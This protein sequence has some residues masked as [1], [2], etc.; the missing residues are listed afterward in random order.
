[1]TRPTGCKTDVSC[2]APPL[3]DLNAVAVVVDGY[4]YSDDF[5]THLYTTDPGI[6]NYEGK[7]RIDFYETGKTTPWAWGE[8]TYQR[9]DDGN[10]SEYQASKPK[11]GR[12]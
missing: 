10:W 12:Y 5:W 8:V 2:C 9:N 3:L 6:I 7:F 1:M 4:R 11:V